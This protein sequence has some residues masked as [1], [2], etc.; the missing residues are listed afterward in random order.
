ML[1]LGA[2][3]GK[4]GTAADESAHDD[5]LLRH[6]RQTREGLTDLDAWDAGR[7]WPPGAVPTSGTA[8]PV[9]TPGMRLK[10]SG[11]PPRA[12]PIPLPP[13]PL[14]RVALGG[15]ESA[16]RG[17]LVRDGSTCRSFRGNHGKLT[18]DAT[19]CACDPCA[20]GRGTC[21]SFRVTPTPWRPRMRWGWPLPPLEQQRPSSRT[22]SAQARDDSQVEHN[23]PLSDVK[24]NPALRPLDDRPRARA[25]R[26]RVVWPPL[27]ALPGPSAAPSTRWPSAWTR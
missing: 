14:P 10:N 23:P 13:F 24:R 7:G 4:A 12:V 11:C 15:R 8:R 25:R 17:Q 5:Q 16:G 9:G 26:G 1:R 20:S 21:R 22:G 19:P 27:R 6:L 18:A 2:S 3:T